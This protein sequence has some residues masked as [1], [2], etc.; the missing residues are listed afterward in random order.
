VSLK[1]GSSESNRET[2]ILRLLGCFLPVLSSS[3]LSSS[4]F[5]SSSSL[6]GGEGIGGAEIALPGG[7]VEEG[8]E[9]AVLG[10]DG[11]VFP[12]GDAEGGGDVPDELWDMSSSGSKTTT[13]KP[14]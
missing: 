6:E 10:R 2:R 3:S 14:L 11:L 8:F 7:E 9:F 4:G 5:P 12:A 1:P 13:W